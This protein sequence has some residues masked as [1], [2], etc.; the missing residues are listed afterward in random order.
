MPET[1]RGIWQYATLWRLKGAERSL[2]QTIAQSR[3]LLLLIQYER[4]EREFAVLERLSS[5][6]VAEAKRLGRRPDPDETT[7]LANRF[8]NYY[9]QFGAIKT[10]IEAELHGLGL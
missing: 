8:A 5:Q 6:M 3:Q 7:R 4:L 10:Q 2:Q 1:P 9:R